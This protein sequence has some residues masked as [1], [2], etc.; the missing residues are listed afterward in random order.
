MS[1]LCVLLKTTVLLLFFRSVGRYVSVVCLHS[2]SFP[3][4][5]T[6][7]VSLQYCHENILQPL[8]FVLESSLRTVNQLGRESCLHPPQKGGIPPSGYKYVTIEGV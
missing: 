7:P 2:I 8:S 3:G 1:V 4:Q 5:L 6:L